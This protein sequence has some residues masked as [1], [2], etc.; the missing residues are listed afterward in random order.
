MG[1]VENDTGD[2]D[3]AGVVEAV[4]HGF[5]QAARTPARDQTRNR[6]WADEF[7]IP[8]QAGS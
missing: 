3:E 4:Q 5:V 8:K 7:D 1:G 6:R 2:V